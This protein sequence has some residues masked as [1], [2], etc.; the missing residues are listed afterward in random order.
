MQ[1]ESVM[2]TLHQPEP[3]NQGI[4]TQIL[5]YIRKFSIIIIIC[6]VLAQIGTI[7][8]VN[9]EYSLKIIACKNKFKN[10]QQ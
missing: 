6:V 4:L 8:C 10:M 2:N 3:T 1:K 9:F 5:H 7:K